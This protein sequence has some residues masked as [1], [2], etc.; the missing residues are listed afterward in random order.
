M[1]WKEI[2]NFDG[3]LISDT[4]EVKST[5]YWGQFKRRNSD[6]LL[7]KRTDKSG[8]QYVNLYKK[9][10]M[11]SVKIHRLVAQ[12]F[13]PNPLGYRQVN[14]KDEDKSNNNISNLEWCNA[15]YNLTYNNLSKKVHEKQ[16]RKIGAYN[17]NGELQMEFDSAT[18]AALSIVE[19]K[20]SLSF[21]SAVSNICMAAKKE[22]KILRYGYYWRWLE[23]SKRK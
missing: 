2:K 10:H 11:Y 1:I 4:G 7:V 3:Y 21:R 8:Y 16:K 20:K 9:G 5:K 12:A 19:F 6:G 18:S 15:A 13:I 23:E 17:E 14:H 22:L